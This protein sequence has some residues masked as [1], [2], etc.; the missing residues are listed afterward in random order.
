MNVHGPSLGI[1][2]GIAVISI[3]AAFFAMDTLVSQNQPLVLEEQPITSPVQSTPTA[4]PEKENFALACV[5]N[6]ITTY[7]FLI[8]RMK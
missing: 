2:A 4:K 1:G 6:Q 8:T 3:M 5:N 7:L